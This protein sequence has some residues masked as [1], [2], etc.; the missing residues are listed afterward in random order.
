MS[1]F[2]NQGQAGGP[3]NE[4]FNTALGNNQTASGSGA[5]GPNGAGQ[6]SATNTNPIDKTGKPISSGAKGK[7]KGK[8]TPPVN[9]LNISGASRMYVPQQLMPRPKL[10]G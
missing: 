10:I 6:K 8:E 5:S 7:G 9:P 3:S 2:T 4:S 1:E